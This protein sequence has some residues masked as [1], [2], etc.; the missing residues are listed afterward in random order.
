MKL[1]NTKNQEIPLERLVK[2]K[3]YYFEDTYESHGTH[4]D[5][6]KFNAIVIFE[7]ITNEKVIGGYC[8]VA[9]FKAL[10]IS[11]PDANLKPGCIINRI[12][13]D[14]DIIIKELEN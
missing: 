4:K 12:T 7:K 6:Y 10:I 11:N 1:Y 3:M 14:S 13:N 5:N 8:D 9:A 2:D